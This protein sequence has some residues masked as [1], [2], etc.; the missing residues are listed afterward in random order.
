[1]TEQ[2]RQLKISIATAK[3][4]SKR[5]VM[6]QMQRTVRS[7]KY[8][9]GTERIWTRRFGWMGAYRASIALGIKRMK[10]QLAAAA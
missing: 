6:G 10:C 9:D 4:N 2:A 8:P 5:L 1:M 3:A 7:K